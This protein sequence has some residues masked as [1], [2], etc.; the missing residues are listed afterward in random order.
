MSF[1]IDVMKGM[2]QD[3]SSRVAS[4]VMRVA[5]CEIVARGYNFLDHQ[6]IARITRNLTFQEIHL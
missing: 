5:Q 1:G 6:E 2:P 3:D 4:C